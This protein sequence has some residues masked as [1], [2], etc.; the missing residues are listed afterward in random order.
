MEEGN[1][2]PQ[3][4]IISVEELLKLCECPVCL[5]HQRDNRV[6]VPCGHS[7]CFKC[8]QHLLHQGN[9]LCPECNETLQIPTN[10]SSFMKD[11]RKNSLVELLDTLNPKKEAAEER[12][13]EC[14]KAAA[15]WC[16]ICK[17]AYCE[18]D[19]AAVGHKPKALQGHQRIPISQKNLNHTP[20]NYFVQYIQTKKW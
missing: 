3:E 16:E 19:D 4:K 10:V 14:G 7:M 12:C 15:V 18:V 1:A 5:E 20:P 6:L 17:T 9:T 2:N 8:I 13:R 11:Y